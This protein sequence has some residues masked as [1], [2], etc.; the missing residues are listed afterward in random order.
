MLEMK[1]LKRDI[2]R[3]GHACMY[4]CLVSCVS[5]KR[6]NRVSHL[7]DDVS[8]LPMCDSHLNINRK[9][10]TKIELSDGLQLRW[11]MLLHSLLYSSSIWICASAFWFTRIKRH[12]FG[13]TKNYY[14]KWGMIHIRQKRTKNTNST[15]R[16]PNKYAV[17][18]SKAFQYSGNRSTI[19]FRIT[20]NKTTFRTNIQSDKTK[21]TLTTELH[22]T[23]TSLDSS[24]WTQITPKLTVEPHQNANAKQFSINHFILNS[25]VWIGWLGICIDSLQRKKK[26]KNNVHILK[27]RV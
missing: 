26:P 27:H 6:L 9:G 18:W 19:N 25:V 16:N 12:S 4:G 13:V 23:E 8:H 14:I 24:N 1:R 10:K 3:I 22:S 7:V 2:K 5:H 21:E 20:K 17:N 15:K 11:L